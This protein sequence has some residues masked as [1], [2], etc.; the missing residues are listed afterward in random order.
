MKPQQAI[1]NLH[2]GSSAYLTGIRKRVEYDRHDLF[3]YDIADKL[4][5]SNE[6]RFD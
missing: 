3:E 4:Q 5:N 1:V 6:R 2:A